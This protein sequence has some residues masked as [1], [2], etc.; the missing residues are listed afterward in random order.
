MTPVSSM[1]FLNI[2]A[3]IEY[4]FTLKRMCDMIKTYSQMQLTHKYSH[5]CSIFWPVWLNGSVFIYE[6]SG[7]GFESPW[8][9]L[10]LRY[11]ACFEQGVP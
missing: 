2:Q 11:G 3:S 5:P 9:H 4:G 1:E 6:L 8:S 10:I 7:Y